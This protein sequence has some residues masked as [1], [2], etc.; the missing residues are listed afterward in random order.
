[1][2]AEASKTRFSVTRPSVPLEAPLCGRSTLYGKRAAERSQRPAPTL[3]SSLRPSLAL[4]Q[5]CQ[6]E[7]SQGESEVAERDIEVAGDQEQVED[8]AT[9]PGGDDVAAE[10]GAQPDEHAGRHL[11]DADDQHEGVTREGEHPLHERREILVPVH[12]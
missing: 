7:G 2:T 11:D 3:S 8:D 4:R 5:P 9:E 10:A 12:Q 6:G 1:M